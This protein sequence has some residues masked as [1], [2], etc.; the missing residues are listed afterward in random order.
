MTYHLVLVDH[1]I[2]SFKN[3]VSSLEGN[4]S[5]NA[6]CI[7]NFTLVMLLHDKAR[8]LRV[9]ILTYHH[10]GVLLVLELRLKLPL[11]HLLLLKL[12]LLILSH[13]LRILLLL[14]KP[15]LLLSHWLLHIRLILSVIISL[16]LLIFNFLV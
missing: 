16:W 5:C 2:L 11:E 14:I 3:I 10:L 13:H 12:S 6:I 8:Q 9:T 7:E 4:G 1:L 15:I